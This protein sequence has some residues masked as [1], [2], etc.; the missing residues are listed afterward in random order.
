MVINIVYDFRV[1]TLNE[2]LLIES[3]NSQ[4]AAFLHSDQRCC[5]TV[6]TPVNPALMQ[7]LRTVG[8]MTS[9]AAR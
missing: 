8:Q 1:Y 3:T 5:T 4:T 7:D 9:I 6:L 2:D